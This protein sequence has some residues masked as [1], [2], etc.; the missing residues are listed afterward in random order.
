MIIKKKNFSTPNPSWTSADRIEEDGDIV[1]E[2]PKLDFDE[3]KYASLREV[4]RQLHDEEGV[5]IGHVEITNVVC[6]C[7]RREPLY[8][9]T[10]YRKGYR[11][12]VDL[13]IYDKENYITKTLEVD[14]L[15][16]ITSIVIPHIN[17]LIGKGYTINDLNWD[18]IDW[19]CNCWDF[20]VANEQPKGRC[21]NFYNDDITTAED[22]YD[23]I[24]TIKVS[25]YVDGINHIGKDNDFWEV[26][27]VELTL[28][29]PFIDR[30][31]AELLFDNPSYDFETKTISY[32]YKTNYHSGYSAVGPYKLDESKLERYR[33]NWIKSLRIYKVHNFDKN[34]MM[35]RRFLKN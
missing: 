7:Y 24:E 16:F 20:S 3:T 29:F 4:G 2:I 8:H 17:I 6:K 9:N 21:L 26:I 18:W 12:I 22:L 23:R 11:Y 25:G 13:Y 19:Q 28:E 27:T 1:I 34:E 32:T 14:D 15:N 5:C 33:E 10:S 30:Y 35:S 31:I